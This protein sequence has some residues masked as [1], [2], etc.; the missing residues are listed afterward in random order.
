MLHLT[1]FF[2]LIR[3]EKEKQVRTFIR[4]FETE[5]IG[6]EVWLTWVGR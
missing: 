3:T 4:S 2:V 5:E 1:C 6:L